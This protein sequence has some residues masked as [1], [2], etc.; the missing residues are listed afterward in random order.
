MKHPLQST[1]INGAILMLVSGLLAILGT[2]FDQGYLTELI[3]AFT[4]ISGAV[5][6]IYGRWKA[7]GKI[8]LRK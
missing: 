6:T 5:I 7:T 4:L 3:N 1:T 2:D 8:S